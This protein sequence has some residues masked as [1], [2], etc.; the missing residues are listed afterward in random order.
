MGFLEAAFPKAALKIFTGNFQKRVF[1]KIIDKK[2][3][4]LGAA[5]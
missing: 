5:F 1:E 3:K 2:E 4:F